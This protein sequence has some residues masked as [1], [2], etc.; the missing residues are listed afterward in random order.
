MKIIYNGNIYLEKNNFAEAICIENGKILSVGSSEEILKL[1]DE[2]TTLIDA[3]KNSVI[4]GF[5]DSHLHLYSVGTALQSVQLYGSKSIG[6]TIEKGREFILKNSIP[7][8][9]FVVGRGWNQDYFTD[10]N[11]MLTK[12]DLDAIS[13][14]HPILY[15]RACGHLAVCNSKALEICNITKDTPQIEGAEFYYGDDG[16]PNGIFTEEAIDL[17]V[18]N[19]PEPSIDDM[20]KTIDLASNYAL[21]HGITSVHTNDIKDENYSLMLEAY[22]K[23]FSLNSLKPRVY[24]QCFFSTPEL[25]KNFI[26]DGYATGAGDSF[27]KIGPLKMFVDGSLGA[28]TALLRNP[29]SDDKSTSGITCLTQNQLDTMVSVAHNN[30]CQVAI[31][32]IGDKAIEMVLDSYDKVIEKKN[33][34]RHGIVHCQ[35]TDKPLLERFIKNDILAYVQP[36][37]IHYDMNITE[38]RVGKELADTSYAFGDMNKMGIKLSYGSDSPVEDLN[39]FDNLYCAVTRKD[40]NASPS[41]GYYPEQRVSLS[42]AIHLYTSAS[43]Y[44]SFEE[45]IKGKLLP[46]YF[47]DLVILD[48]D[49]FSSDIEN[50]RDTK[51]LMTMVNGEIA[52][53]KYL[54]S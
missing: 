42:D 4:P 43:A 52:Y 17:I 16:E 29:Y 27:N 37:F 11:R 25:F 39:T 32:A 34:N 9:E 2:N 45:D 22:T 41:K 8:G 14:E 19:I 13:T 48:R 49:I 28:R 7:S 44:G 47:A 31:H 54:R 20:V 1:A 53:K 35:I 12:H 18:K 3:K 15:K 26:E 33:I 21:S 36:I 38:N 51:V 23:A 10:E 40:L 24:H 46:N 50:L 6:E 30:N 5:N